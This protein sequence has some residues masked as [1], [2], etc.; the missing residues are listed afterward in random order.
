MNIPFRHFIGS[1]IVFPLVFFFFFVPLLDCLCW[2]FRFFES[3]TSCAYL[4]NRW[5]DL[6]RKRRHNPLAHQ[7]AFFFEFPTSVPR[8]ALNFQHERPVGQSAA[9][10][11]TRWYWCWY[12]KHDREKAK[13]YA[14]H[15][16]I[17]LQI[18]DTNFPAL[19]R[20]LI[21]FFFFFFLCVCVFFY[22]IFKTCPQHVCGLIFGFL[23]SFLVFILFHLKIGTKLD[24]ATLKVIL[25]NGQ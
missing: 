18:F 19:N 4:V 13:L 15:K 3:Y 17:I 12:S 7:R 24:E 22:P 20:K 9:E 6:W 25:M 16:N 23:I 5:F 10:N 2:M 1:F 11:C 21:F 8:N 14:R